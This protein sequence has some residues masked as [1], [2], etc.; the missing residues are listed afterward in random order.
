MQY[1]RMYADESGES[2]F[3]DVDVPLAG[4]PGRPSSLS[5]V[6]KSSG[7]VFRHTAADYDLDF[8]TAPRRQ[9]VVNLSGGVEIEVSDGEVRRFGP[10]TVFLAEDTT[11]RGH[12]SRAIDGQERLSIFVHLAE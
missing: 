4:T 2:H 3:Q 9:F 8:H 11:G 10:G 12:K 5:D 6:F 7:I 1:T